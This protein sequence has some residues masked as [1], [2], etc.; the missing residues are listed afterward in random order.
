[1]SGL[2]EWLKGKKTYVVAAAVLLIAVLEGIVGIDIPGAEVT[3]P[4]PYILA[5]LG[6][7]ALRAGVSKTS[8]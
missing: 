1:M 3:N 2:V 7:G 5:A 8:S 4:L 6:L